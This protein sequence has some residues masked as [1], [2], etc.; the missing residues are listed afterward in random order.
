MK[1]AAPRPRGTTT[2]RGQSNVIGLV[3]VL[4]MVVVGVGLVVALGA[5]A[6]DDTQQQSELERA[7]HSMTLFDSKASMVALGDSPTQQVSFGQDGGE[8]VGAD[9]SGWLRVTHS[10]YSLSGTDEVMFNESLGAVVYENGGTEIAYQG[11][12]VWRKDRQGEARMVSPPEFHYRGATLTLPI[13][14]VDDADSGGSGSG[15]TISRVGETRRVFPNATSPTVG[16][17]E[18]GAPYN[19]TDRQYTNPVANGTVNITVKSEY[20]AGWAEYFRAHTEGDVKVFPNDNRVRVTLESLAGSVGSFNMPSEGT[21]LQIQGM[22]D[23]HPVNAYSLTLK[24]DGNYQNMHWAMYADGGSEK[25]EL[26]F[27]S[28]GQCTGSGYN[29][30]L[31]VSIYYKNTSGGTT[32]E[33]EWQRKNID[34]DSNYDFDIDCTS[35][36]LSLDLVNATGSTDTTLEY[37]ETDLTGNENKWYFGPEI[38]ANTISGPTTSFDVHGSTDGPYQYSVGESKEMGFLIN[39]YFQLLGPSYELTVTDGPASSS[40]VDEGAS[41][42]T[43]EFDTSSGAQYITFLHITENRVNVSFD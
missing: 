18:I 2:A 21:S 39:H 13:I 40:R 23:N 14:R 3:L 20:Y 34:L 26:H 12:G 42:G 24:P 29:G 10:N 15:A 28:D 5:A 17:P 16:S 25:F 30:D 7:E 35:G 36:E 6:L 37:G 43:L 41:S 4:A 9:D 27:W 38:D 31:D 22:G 32:V 1:I 11:G 19:S 8:F 33:E